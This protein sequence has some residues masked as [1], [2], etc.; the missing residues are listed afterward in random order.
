[1]ESRNTLGALLLGIAI[2][3]GLAALG[4][5]DLGRLEVVDGHTVLAAEPTEAA[6]KR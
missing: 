5:D 2:A 6:A 1:M 3:V 4:G